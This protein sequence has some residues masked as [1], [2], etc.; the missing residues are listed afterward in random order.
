MVTYLAIMM[1]RKGVCKSGGHT[2]DLLLMVVMVVMLLNGRR[3]MDVVRV[4]NVMRG[5]RRGRI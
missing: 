3:V 5:R 4:M 1:M 2:V